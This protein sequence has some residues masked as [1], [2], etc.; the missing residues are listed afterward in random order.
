MP[1]DNIRY[2]SIF[3]ERET[4]ILNLEIIVSHFEARALWIVEQGIS[5]SGRTNSGL[6]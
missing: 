2:I 6:Y 4:K 5:C 1:I 3:F